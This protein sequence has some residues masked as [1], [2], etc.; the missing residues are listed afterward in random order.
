MKQRCD[1]HILRPDTIHTFL[2]LN[3]WLCGPQFLGVLPITHGVT[4]VLQSKERLDKLNRFA[5]KLIFRRLPTARVKI[6]MRSHIL[7]GTFVVYVE[8]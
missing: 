7:I 1:Y 8:Q 5:R 2:P 6:S 3:V 4:R